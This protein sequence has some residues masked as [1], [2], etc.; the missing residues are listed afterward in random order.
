MKKDKLMEMWGQFGTDF[1]PF[2]VNVMLD[3]MATGP[4]AEDKYDMHYN[5]SAYSC[6]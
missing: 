6:G 1:E 4:V 2:F 3:M 5:R